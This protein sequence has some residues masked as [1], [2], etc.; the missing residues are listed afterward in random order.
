MESYHK[1]TLNQHRS[2]LL[3]LLFFFFL[4]LF[5]NTL[6]R[7]TKLHRPHLHYL[8]NYNSILLWSIVVLP[9]EH[10]EELIVE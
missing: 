1:G 8:Q 9:Q 3:A 10:I 2:V 7:N 5:Y 4:L 6:V